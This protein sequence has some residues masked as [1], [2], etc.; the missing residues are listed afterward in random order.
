MCAVAAPGEAEGECGAATCSAATADATTALMHKHHAGVSPPLAPLAP[1]TPLQ[2]LPTGLPPRIVLTLARGQGGTA[3][4][5]P[6]QR[7]WGDSWQVAEQGAKAGLLLAAVV[8]FDDTLWCEEGYTSRGYKHSEDKGFAVTEARS[9]I[10]VPAGLG[11]AACQWPPPRIHV[12]DCSFWLCDSAQEH[13]EALA[14]KTEEKELTAT[15]TAAQSDEASMAPAVSAAANPV[16]GGDGSNLWLV[17]GIYDGSPP[18]ASTAAPQAFT[19]EGL[20]AAVTATAGVHGVRLVECSLRD[21]F[22]HPLKRRHSKCYRIAYAAHGDAALS[23]EGARELHA[24]VKAT[25]EQH[26]RVEVRS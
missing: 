17:G 9:H 13:R 19:E 18:P 7:Q 24:L 14:R 8:P 12:F 21:E 5:A 11:V 20:R 3:A 2:L 15:A 16:G 25:L 22:E 23:V 6:H 26:L 4:D 1:L 10:L